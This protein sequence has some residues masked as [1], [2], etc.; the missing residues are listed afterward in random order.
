M[1]RSDRIRFNVYSNAKTTVY[2]S[3]LIAIRTEKAKISFVNDHGYSNFKNVAL[4]RNYQ[5]RGI[6]VI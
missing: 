6:P 3:D 5:S 4:I 1:G 2:L